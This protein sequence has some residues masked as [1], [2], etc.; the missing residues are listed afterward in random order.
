MAICDPSRMIFGTRMSFMRLAR[1]LCIALVPFAVAGCLSEGTRARLFNSPPLL[2]TGNDPDNAQIQYVI[3][4]RRA[5]TEEINR[6]AWDRV[7]EQILSF[8]T[9]AVLD[10]V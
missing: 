5:G 3:I 10:D 6:R 9:R 2:G 7:D 1:V 4:E 8:E